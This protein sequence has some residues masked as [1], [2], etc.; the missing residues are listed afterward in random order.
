MTIWVATWIL[1]S[2][3]E[4]LLARLYNSSLIAGGS[5]DSEWKKG[6]DGPNLLLKFWRTASMLYDSTYLTTYLNL[7]V[8]SRID[9]PFCFRIVCRELM[10]LFCR[11]E[12]RYCD[13]NADDSSLNEFIELRGSLLNQANACPHKLVGEYFAQ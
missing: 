11:I 4:Y 9:S 3:I 8:K 13:M 6:V 1:Y 2:N 5:K 7:L 12:Q 10:F